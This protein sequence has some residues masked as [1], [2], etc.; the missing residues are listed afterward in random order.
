MSTQFKINVE[1]MSISGCLSQSTPQPHSFENFESKAKTMGTG[2][3]KLV[4]STTCLTACEKNTLETRLISN[5][6]NIPEND[7]TA[8]VYTI[9]FSKLDE[10]K[11]TK[12]I[13]HDNLSILV[14]YSCKNNKVRSSL[15]RAS[16]IP[17]VE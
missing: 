10:L 13:S 8:V 4:P 2:F 14:F 7:D 15:T 12:E 11:Q 5:T 1:T 9:Q 16:H 17:E 6:I 3:G